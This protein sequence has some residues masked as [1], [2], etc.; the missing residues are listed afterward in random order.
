[1]FFPICNFHRHS[2]S[3]AL[4]S[5]LSMDYS[6][7]RISLFDRAGTLFVDD[8]SRLADHWSLFV[9]ASHR[10]GKRFAADAEYHV[11]DLENAVSG[12]ALLD[13]LD[14]DL[15]GIGGDHLVTTHP[16]SQARGTQIPVVFCVGG[17][18]RPMRRENDGE[19]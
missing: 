13:L 11:S 18:A 7:Y 1:M 19:C 14:R 3:N 5:Y 16:A 4:T 12:R 17:E 6:D 2:K 8:L 15:A 10:R 9:S